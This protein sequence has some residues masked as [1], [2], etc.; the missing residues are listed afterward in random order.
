MAQA[1]TLFCHASR[2]KTAIS[3]LLK[4]NLEDLIMMGE[5]QTI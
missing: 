3:T 1:E 2:L 5:I 4:V